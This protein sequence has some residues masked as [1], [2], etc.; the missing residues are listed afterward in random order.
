SSRDERVRLPTPEPPEQAVAKA[1]GWPR[2][3][4]VRDQRARKDHGSLFDRRAP[5]ATKTIEQRERVATV[6]FRAV[7]VEDRRGCL[8][9][10]RGS[11]VLHLRQR[12]RRI[13]EILVERRAPHTRQRD[14][15]RHGART[16]RMSQ[17]RR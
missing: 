2:E 3:R 1:R 14:D 13:V 4:S 11:A 6:T 12:V 5:R 7:G 16:A 15:F 17:R 9:K 10:A 8:L